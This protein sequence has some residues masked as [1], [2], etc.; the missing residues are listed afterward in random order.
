[1]LTE[2]MCQNPF[3]TGRRGVSEACSKY[4]LRVGGVA[5]RSMA[6]VLKTANSLRVRGFESHPLRH[7]NVLCDPIKSQ[8]PPVS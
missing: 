5:E 1:M 2:V 7:I 3:G 8:N 6:A 4:K